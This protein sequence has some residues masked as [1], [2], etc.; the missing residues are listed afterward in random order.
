[1][2]V[3][4]TRDVHHVPVRME[5]DFAFGAIVAEA[6]GYKPGQT[7]VLPAVAASGH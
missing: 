6:T 2:F 5:A 7:V 1:M 4:F 3:Y